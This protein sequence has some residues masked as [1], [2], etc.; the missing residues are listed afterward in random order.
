MKRS[1]GIIIHMRTRGIRVGVVAL[2][3]AFLVVTLEAALAGD[4]TFTKI[5][6]TADGVFT[7]F[8]S[9]PTINNDGVVAFAADRSVGGGGVFTGSGGALRKAGKRSR[10]AVH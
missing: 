2:T 6:D 9:N 5:A 7:V 3:I 1:S 8:R 4:Y 10:R